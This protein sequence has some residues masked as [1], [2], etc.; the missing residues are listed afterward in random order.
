MRT[1][2]V[3]KTTAEKQ[4]LLRFVVG[5]D[6][7]IVFDAHNNL[8]GRGMWIHAH[9][10]CLKKALDSR[11]FN[12]IAKGSVQIPANFYDLIQTQL[13]SYCKEG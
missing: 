1:C 8:P 9:G 2:F 3:C 13:N 7:T 4:K 12:K 6:N 11:L 5:N 10:S